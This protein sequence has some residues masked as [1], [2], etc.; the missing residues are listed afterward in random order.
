M[1]RGMIN[2]GAVILHCIE[3][4]YLQLEIDRQ[5]DRESKIYEFIRT[6]TQDKE[7]KLFLMNVR[8]IKL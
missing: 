2:T 8:G 3:R 5:F 4:I 6:K 7:K 1:I